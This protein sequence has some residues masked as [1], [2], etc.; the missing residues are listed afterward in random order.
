[1]ANF[2]YEIKTQDGKYETG[3]TQAES[4]VELARIFKSQGAV[5]IRASRQEKKKNVFEFN[6]WPSRVPLSDKLMITRNLHIMIGTGLS[7]SKSFS[8]LS[9][10]IKNKTLKEA[11]IDVQEHIGRGEKMSDSLAKYPQLF[12][13]IFINMIA[14]GEMSGT[15]ENSLKVLA[16]QIE[17]EYKLR[18]KVRGA[19]IYPAILLTVMLIAGGVVLTVFVPGLKGLFQ[20][21]NVQLPIYTKIVLAL[22]DFMLAY[23][24]IIILAIAISIPLLMRYFKTERGKW[25]RD[26]I[27]LKTPLFSE[28]AKKANSASSIRSLT[29]LVSSG[30]SLEK[31]LDITSSTVSNMYFKKAFNEAAEKIRK[32]ERLS[33]ALSPH[34]DIFIFGTLETM[35]VGEETG[36]TPVLLKKLADFYEEEVM[37]AA[38]NLSSLI[39]PILIVFL[40]ISVGIFAFSVLSPLYSVLNQIH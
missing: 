5:L 31:S 24:Y 15:L 22:G 14:A 16:L 1:M 3:F 11:L 23:W 18:S 10:Q 7:L 20:G 8:L 25:V 37:S 38:D 35:E 2:Y 21:L 33:V 9:S 28:L 13:E 19:L 29:S 39:E 40:G 26:T 36:E 17:K 6:L 27:I 12:S 4:D 34:K 32:G 30:V